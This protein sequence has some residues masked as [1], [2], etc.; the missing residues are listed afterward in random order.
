[1][2]GTSVWTPLRGAAIVAVI[3]CSG[4]PARIPVPGYDPAAI[5]AQ[6]V[7]LLDRDGDGKISAAE[8]EESKSLDSAMERLDS[9]GDGSLTAEEIAKRI[10]S[11]VDFKSGLVPA[12]CTILKGGRPVADAKVTYEPEPFMG[13]S[14]VP[15]TG[16]TYTDGAASVSMSAE[17]LPSPRFE[18]VRPGFYRVRLTLPDGKEV[19]NL[20]A[21]VECAGGLINNHTIVLP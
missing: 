14:L 12:Y 10:Q 8:R 3:G 15:A 16:T 1:M 4:K 19:T 5:G 18:G 20:N 9:N 11:Y 17:H 13:D 2:R 7:E 21:G 6:A